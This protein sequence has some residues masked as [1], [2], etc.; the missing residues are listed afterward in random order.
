MIVPESSA[1]LE[2]PGEVR[3]GLNADH[4]TIAKYSS[5]RDPN[6]VKLATTLR[7]IVADVQVNDANVRHTTTSDNS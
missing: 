4:L 2:Y 5:N 7:K 3:V 1:T 6:F